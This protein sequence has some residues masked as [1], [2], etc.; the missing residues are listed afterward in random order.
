M[1]KMPEEKFQFD[2]FVFNILEGYYL[3]GAEDQAHDMLMLFA[4]RL[5]EELAF[6]AQFKGKE[7]KMVENEI[8]AASQYYGLLLQLQ[9]QYEGDGGRGRESLQNTE[10]F[11]RYVEAL[12]PFGRA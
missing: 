2:Y 12:R 5:D 9:S 10:L 7:R 6:Y 4:D 11:P 3:A 8:N 1:E